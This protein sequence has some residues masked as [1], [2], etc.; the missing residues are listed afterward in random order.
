[1]IGEKCA[2]MVL[3]VAV[4]DVRVRR[5]NAAIP[6]NDLFRFPHFATAP[7]GIAVTVHSTTSSR[8]LS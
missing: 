3:E 7:R 4:R 2:A 8:R 6:C 5:D 1:M